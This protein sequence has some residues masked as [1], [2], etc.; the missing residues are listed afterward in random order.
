M[1]LIKHKLG[2]LITLSEE[3]NSDNKYSIENVKGVSIRKI[4]IE[5]KASMSGVSLTPYLV[6]KPDYFAYV[7]VTSRNGNKITIAHNET[8]DTYIVSSS[9]IVFYVSSPEIIDS[10]YLFMYFNR[11]EF[12]RY[13]RFHSW[14]SAREVFSWSEMCAMQISLPLIEIQ[15]KYVAVFKALLANN[16]GTEDIAN[17]CSILIKGA[18]EEGGR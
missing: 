8:N 18:I 14:G 9:Y 1:A 10:D 7:P 11:P 15:R 17:I 16:N 13:S 2:N 4:F 12:D 3:K 6:V 5:T